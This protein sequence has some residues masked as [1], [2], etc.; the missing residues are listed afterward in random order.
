MKTKPKLYWDN[1]CFKGIRS[2]DALH[3]GCAKVASVDCFL[4][5]DL[6]I[7]KKRLDEIYCK[8]PENVRN[9]SRKGA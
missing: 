6:G 1:C 4:T 2:M 5:T 3:L 7:L 8:R 9:K